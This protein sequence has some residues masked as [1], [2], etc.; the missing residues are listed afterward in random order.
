MTSFI[1]A[2]GSGRSTSVIPAVPAASSVTTIAFIGIVSSPVSLFGGSRTN[3]DD[4]L[5]ADPLGR[6]EGGD[7][8]VEGRDVA[9]VG[10]QSS[11]PNPLDDLTQLGTIGLDDEVDCQPVGG[12]RLGRPYDGH[13]GSSGPD[14][15]CGPLLDVSADDVE[16]QVHAADVFQ[17]VVVEVDEL[18]CTEVERPVTVGSASGADDVGAELACELRDHRTD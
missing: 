5:P 18:L 15:A 13:Q 12:P 14:Q 17:G 9:D 6:V 8:I 3:A 4:R 2:G 16:H 11:V 7:G 10:P 1:A